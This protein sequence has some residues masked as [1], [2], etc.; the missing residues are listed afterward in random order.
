M[1]PNNTKN[2]S[3]FILVVVAIRLFLSY[4]KYL[5][6]TGT[7]LFSLTAIL[8]IVATINPHFS[9]EFLQYFSFL[10]PSYKTESFSMG[11]KEIMEIFSITALFLWIVLAPIKFFL[12]KK[13]GFN[14][15]LSLKSKIILSFVIISLLYFFTL[16]SA[17]LDDHSNNNSYFVFIVFYIFNLISMLGYFLLNALL[18]KISNYQKKK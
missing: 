3:A 12:K 16:L 8:L 15:T 14:T 11:K 2:E 4:I 9:F 6:L 5:F 17:K 13:F 1:E 18:N 10:N 7:I